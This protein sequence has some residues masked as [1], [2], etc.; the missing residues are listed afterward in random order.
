MSEHSVDPEL[1]LA[2]FLRVASA[3]KVDLQPGQII[4]ERQPAPHSPPSR[5]PDGKMAAYCFVWE[6]KCLKVGKAGPKSH[7]R[8]A[9]QHYS[10]GSSKSNLAKSILKS[11]SAM[12]LPDVDESNIGNWIRQNAERWNFLIDMGLGESPFSTSLKHFFNAVC[13]LCSKDSRASGRARL[14]S[15][16]S[17]DENFQPSKN[18]RAQEIL[19]SVLQTCRVRGVQ[20]LTFLCDLIQS[21]HPILVPLATR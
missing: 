7:A 6:G 16:P 19:L 13:G 9:S 10:L 11:K 17:M 15:C 1:L 4:A 8:Y 18:A 21:P 2:D 20:A 3:A 14:L 12:G 5:I